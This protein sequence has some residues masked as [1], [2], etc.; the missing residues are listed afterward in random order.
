M[1]NFTNPTCKKCGKPAKIVMENDGGCN[2]PECCG[3]REE[4]AEVHCTN[5]KCRATERV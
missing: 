5:K 3:G 1:S 2:D 4:W